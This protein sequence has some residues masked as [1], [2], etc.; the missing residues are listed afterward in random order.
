MNVN[1]PYMNGLVETQSGRGLIPT[2]IS[3]SSGFALVT[4]PQGSAVGLI[5]TTMLDTVAKA[6]LLSI[7]QAEVRLTALKRG[8]ESW[9]LEQKHFLEAKLKLAEIK[10]Q[11]QAAKLNVA[12]SLATRVRLDTHAETLRFDADVLYARAE[13]LHRLRVVFGQVRTPILFLSTRFTDL[14]K[15]AESKWPS[16]GTLPLSPVTLSVCRIQRSRRRHAGRQ[17]YPF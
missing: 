17:R 10:Y 16:D 15:D 4:Q 13:A 6:R 7:G 8:Q 11:L 9:Q 14:R 1:A 5:P 12:H 2:R 3:S